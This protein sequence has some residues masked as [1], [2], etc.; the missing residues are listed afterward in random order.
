[1]DLA[2]REAQAGAES[3]SSGRSKAQGPKPPLLTV[4]PAQEYNRKNRRP[5]ETVTASDGSHY[6]CSWL[7]ECV[8]VHSDGNVTCGLDDPHGQRSFGNVKESSLEEIYRNPEYV[9]LQE[10]LWDGHRCVGCTHYH[11]VD[12]GSPPP[13]SHRRLPT[14]LVVETTVKCN[15]RCP[16]TACIPNNDVHSKTRDANWLSLE[17]LK[18]VTDQVSA[19]LETIHF[20]NYG[21]PFLNRQAE[22]MM[23]YLREKC[24]GALMGTSTNA[25]L[26][27]DPSRAEKV[28]RAAPDKIIVTISGITQ[29]V[30]GIYHAAGKCERALAGLKNLC[31]AKR[32]LGRTKPTIIVRYLVFHWNDGDEEID[33]AI[34]LA[35]EYG[36]DHLVLHLTDQPEGAFPEILAGE[37]ELQQVSPA[38]PPRPRGT[39]RSSLPLRA[40]GRGRA[41]PSRWICRNSAGSGG[42]PAGRHCGERPEWP[43]PTGDR[44]RSAIEPREGAIL[45]PPD[46]LAADDQGPPDPRDV[47][48]R[49]DPRPPRVSP[50][51]AG[52]DQAHD[53]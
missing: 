1:M 39:P 21:E 17:T 20:Y 36:A 53:G 10:K 45:P 29:E 25:I 9:N 19:S 5:S 4:L 30:Y 38:H 52:G 18:H 14:G 28:I 51:R 32:R 37:P 7:E 47:A 2:N 24:P 44:H 12:E 27:A 48:A 6:R 31:D 35:K 42:P 40:P 11:R 33:G 23:L 22:D 26:L 46:P 13:A 8:T 43:G 16:N 41:V 49:V 50:Q 3:T 15:L 34:A